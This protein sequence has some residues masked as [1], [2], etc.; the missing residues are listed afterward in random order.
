MT[1]EDKQA[2]PAMPHKRPELETKPFDIPVLLKISEI[3]TGQA[4][5]KIPRATTNLPTISN[6]GYQKLFFI[7]GTIRSAKQVLGAA[8]I[9]LRKHSEPILE[10][11]RERLPLLARHMTLTVGISINYG[12]WGFGTKPNYFYASD[13]KALVRQLQQVN[14]DKIPL[15]SFIL[16]NDE[17]QWIIFHP[18]GDSFTATQFGQKMYDE[19]PPDSLMKMVEK[20]EKLKALGAYVCAMK[21][22]TYKG[23]TCE[24]LHMAKGE[25]A[26]E[27]KPKN[28]SHRW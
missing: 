24:P 12:S 19:I 16:P 8:F 22:A 20:D 2:S 14:F 21:T 23:I 10:S 25:I 18:K 1:D 3:P 13:L 28:S 4:V 6:A 17:C 27:K 15:R 5:M 26:L 7:A 11:A 9:E